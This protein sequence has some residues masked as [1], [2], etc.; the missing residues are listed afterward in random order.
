[1]SDLFH[2]V[3][4]SPGDDVPPR[5]NFDVDRMGPNPGVHRQDR[6]RASFWNYIKN[7]GP[8]WYA[9]SARLL[10]M[11]PLQRLGRDVQAEGEGP[12]GVGK[13]HTL[14]HFIFTT[15]PNTLTWRVRRAI[16]A[17]FFHH[18]N[19]KVIVHSNTLPQ[20]GT[21]LDVFAESGYDLEVRPYRLLQWMKDSPSITEREI[22]E[23]QKVLPSRNAGQYWYSHKTDLVRLLLMERH[24]G[25][26]LDTDQH[27]I[28]P[29]P[30][31]FTNVLGYQ[32]KSDERYKDGFV[33]GAVMIFDRANPFIQGVIKEAINIVTNKYVPTEWSIIGPYLLTDKW[34]EREENS[35]THLPVQVVEPD[36]FY[37]YYWE[38]SNRCFDER[39]TRNFDPVYNPI[40]NNTYT[41]HLNTKITAHMDYTIPGT[42]CD[43]LFHD[44]CI[45]C[46]EIYT[47][48][49][50]APKDRPSPLP[51]PQQGGKL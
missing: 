49:K 40:T 8:H 39:A 27:L 45:Y 38:V 7:R 34:K 48:F 22:A 24:G 37:P 33:N 4:Y 2:H 32:E 6:Y 3:S 23:F 12:P 10:G 50:K 47:D 9:D 1:M 43:S 11:V 28:K 13:V 42:V 36:F 21:R 18:P 16:E 14:F 41:V 30:K 25:V 46:D 29:I 31:S 44:H 5:W 26:Y 51:P 17:V 15:P 35:L 19:A 20:K